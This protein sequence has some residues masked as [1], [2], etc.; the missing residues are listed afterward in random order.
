[1]RFKKSLV[2]AAAVFSAA[3]GWSMQHT[4]NAR[5]ESVTPVTPMGVTIQTLG[6]AMRNGVFSGSSGRQQA[7]ADAKG[8]TLYTYEKDEEPNKSTCY[9]ECATAWPA[10]IAPK[11]A[12]AFGDWTVVTRDDGGKQWAYKGKPLYTFVKDAA[13]GDSTGVT[14]P[15]P[16]GG[17]AAGAGGRAGAGAAATGGA[18]ASGAAAPATPAA[19]NPWR[20][21]AFQTTAG[22]PTPYGIGVQEVADA[23]GQALVDLNEMTLYTFD[24]DPNRDQAACA[25]PPCDSLWAPVSTAQLANPTGDFTLISR[26]DGIRQWAY[27]GKGLYTFKGD[28]TIGDANGIGVDKRWS[29]ALLKSYYMPAQA[30]I[31]ET[32]SRGKVIATA[33]GM[34]LYRRNSYTFQVSGHALPRGVAIIPAMGRT[35]G[36]RSCDAECEK[37]WIPFLAPQDAQPAGF[38]EV[39]TRAD[40]SKQWSYKGYALYRYAGDKKPGDVKG[41]D[42][43][44]IFTNNHLQK[45]SNTT[46]EVAIQARTGNQTGLYWSHMYP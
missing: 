12:K 19:P 33:D 31:Q 37:T 45:V 2:V 34:T 41:W 21:A 38:W 23:N 17:G 28:L 13:P 26:K 4:A 16:P 14:P 8:M 22:I 44:D 35:I 1:M 9:G 40:G 29:V 6:V 36:T 10:L 3:G 27:K 11:N 42:S 7:F 5:Q 18:A 15:R 20:V 46:A 25:T 32:P 24:G 39:M 43:F 30:R